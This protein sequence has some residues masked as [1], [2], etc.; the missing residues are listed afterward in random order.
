MSKYVDLLLFHLFTFL[1]IIFISL[2]K[3]S[4]A[5][6]FYKGLK[7]DDMSGMEL[8]EFD[9]LKLVAK[10]MKDDS[11]ITLEDLCTYLIFV[12]FFLISH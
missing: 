5:F 10:E 4:K 6:T 12:L 7:K 1:N 2:Q 3:A 9:N 11:S 8:A